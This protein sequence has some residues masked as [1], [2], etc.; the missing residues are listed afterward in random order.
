MTT[1]AI[2]QPAYMPRMAY[3]DRF[4]QADISIILDH[5]QYGTGEY[6]NR[7]MI[8]TGNPIYPRQFITVPVKGKGHINKAIKDVEIADQKWQKKHWRS[9]EQNYRRAPHWGEHEEYFKWVY[10]QEWATLAGLLS[11]TL[12]FWIHD[13]FDVGD[14]YL[15]SSGFGIDKTVKGSDMVLY[16]C[17]SVGADKYLTGIN[18]YQYLEMEKFSKFGIEVIKHEY[19]ERPYKQVYK[20]WEGNLSA[21][22][23]LMNVG[24]P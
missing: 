21:I 15:W 9:I 1:V 24:K 17:Q 16:L 18:G 22:D 23:Y 20:G 8:R 12:D 2:N 11:N 14:N 6:V 4:K 5:V 13:I 19:E 7:N 10:R 3:L